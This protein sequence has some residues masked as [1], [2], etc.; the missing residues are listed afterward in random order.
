[1]S[2]KF[3]QMLDAVNEAEQTLHA[4]D[5]VADKMA[6]LLVGRLRKV[7]SAWVLKALKREL[8]DFNMHTQ[9]WK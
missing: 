4:A 8:A 5:S 2:N 3:D 6:R 9:E 1:M 7:R